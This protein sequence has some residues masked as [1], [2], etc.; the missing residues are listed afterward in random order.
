M[1]PLFSIVIP[2]YN[3]AALLRR[4]LQ[5]CLAQEGDFEIVVVDDASTDSS[6]EAA[7]AFGET[8]VRVVSHPRNRGVG[9]ARNSGVAQARGEWII[10]LDS[11]DE[12]LPG[13]IAA[14]TRTAR[15]SA[16]N[17]DGMRFMV[18]FDTGEISPEPPLENEVWDYEAYL[19]W[20][21]ACVGGRQETLP[22]VRRATFDFVRYSEGRALESLYHLDFARR[23]RTFA[24]SEIVRLYH[25]DAPDQL[26]KASPRESMRSAADQARQTE[27]L[28][29]S[30][31]E[32]LRRWAPRLFRQMSAGLATM[33]FLAGDRASGTRAALSSLREQP[34]SLR[35]WV[36][37]GAGMLGPAPLAYVKS[38]RM[39]S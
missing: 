21:D 3:R 14:M 20:A 36:V 29:R 12:L 8:R 16:G 13:A 11:D 6:A 1:T 18:R 30:H 32:A 26:T 38:L 28:L 25:H 19:R 23:Y 37:L 7:R 39:R 22:V 10:C 24:S 33:Y 27:E 9:P 35:Q 17:V 34:L 5:S 15:E 4:A 2:V 31:G